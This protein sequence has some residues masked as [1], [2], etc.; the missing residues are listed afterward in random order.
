MISE[1]KGGGAPM[2]KSY[3]ITATT[4]N[5]LRVL[6]RIAS[7]FSRLRINVEQL[8]VNETDIKGISQFKITILTSE[9]RTVEKLLGQLRRIVELIEV[10]TTN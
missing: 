4:E 3:Q 6:Q 8:S 5:K 2:D 10:Y 7:I 1:D 9:P